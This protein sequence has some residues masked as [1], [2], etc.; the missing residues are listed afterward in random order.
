MVALTG[1]T[2]VEH[3]RA[4]RLLDQ[5]PLGLRDEPFALVSVV[6]A[7]DLDADVQ[8]CPVNDNR[9]LEA[10]VDQGFLQA[11]SAPL[12]G[13]IEQSDAGGGS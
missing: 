4:V 6:A 12:G 7:D 10:L 2:P 5:P 3:Q 1:Q 13:L 8:Q 9:F 11:H